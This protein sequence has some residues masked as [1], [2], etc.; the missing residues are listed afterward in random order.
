MLQG[1]G[2]LWEQM[3]QHILME[4][5]AANTTAPEP[6]VQLGPL[7]PRTM[8][9]ELS[10]GSWPMATHVKVGPQRE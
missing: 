9:A 2:H 1:E 5:G 3:Q 6:V 7:G 4:P 8:P 10:L